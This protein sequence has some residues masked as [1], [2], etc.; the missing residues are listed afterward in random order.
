MKNRLQ[1][2]F[3]WSVEGNKII[4]YDKLKKKKSR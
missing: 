3:S 1:Y 2:T 4:V